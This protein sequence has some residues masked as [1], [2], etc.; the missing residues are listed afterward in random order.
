MHLYLCMKGTNGQLVMDE[1]TVFGCCSCSR[2]ERESGL[3]CS[4]INLSNN[5]VVAITVEI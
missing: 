4:S 3:Q 2:V 5:K 1:R